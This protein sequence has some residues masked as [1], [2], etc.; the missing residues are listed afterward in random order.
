MRPHAA[1]LATNWNPPLVPQRISENE[2]SEGRER[3]NLLKHSETNQR[4]PQTRVPSA[5]FGDPPEAQWIINEEGVRDVVDEAT[6]ANTSQVSADSAGVGENFFISGFVVR[7]EGMLQVIG[8]RR[9]G[10]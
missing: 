1:E 10:V 6:Y 9:E 7:S 4:V 3:E 2:G 8:L 5:C